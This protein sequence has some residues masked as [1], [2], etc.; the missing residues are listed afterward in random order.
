MLKSWLCIRTSAF[1]TNE[2]CLYRFWQI[3]R[4][5]NRCVKQLNLERSAGGR[6]F[7][8]D[9]HERRRDRAESTK[10]LMCGWYGTLTDGKLQDTHKAWRRKGTIVSG[11][12]PGRFEGCS[13]PR[14]NAMAHLVAAARREPLEHLVPAPP[15][16][17]LANRG[18]APPQ[19]ITLKAG[20]KS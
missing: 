18:P 3:R 6:M 2:L 20:F 1:D 14:C 13:Q 8:N 9:L 10:L 11:T 7:M 16:Q 15:C 19:D 5:K 4:S 12:I 17:W